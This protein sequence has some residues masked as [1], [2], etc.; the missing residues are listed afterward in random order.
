[1]STTGIDHYS[2]DHYRILGLPSGEK[3]ARLTG[4]EISKAFKLKALVL[5]PDK[6]P[7]DPNAQANFQRLKSSYETLMDPAA[8]RRFDESLRW[9]RHKGWS[10]EADDGAAGQ[11]RNDGSDEFL[12]F[13]M[14]F[15]KH[16]SPMSHGRLFVFLFVSVFWIFVRMVRFVMKARRCRLG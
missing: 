2:I 7:Q 4:R 13:L 5:H 3:G 10:M 8:R 14:E 16:D 1:M 9:R 15:M 12:R 6:R 11:I